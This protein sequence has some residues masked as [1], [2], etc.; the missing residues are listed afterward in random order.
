MKIR[1]ST[2]AAAVKPSA[3][4]L[5]APAGSAGN[6]VSALASAATTHRFSTFAG[7]R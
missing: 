1:I 6:A 2:S 4:L 7:R 5:A 3:V